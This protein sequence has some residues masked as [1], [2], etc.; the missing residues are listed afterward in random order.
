MEINDYGNQSE[1][2]SKEEGH[3]E[4]GRKEEVNLFLLMLMKTVPAKAG[5]VVSGPRKSRRNRR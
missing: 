1:E 3:Q 4:E 5:T 2:V